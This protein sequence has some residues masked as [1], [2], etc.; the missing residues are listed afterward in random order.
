MKKIVSFNVAG[1]ASFYTTRLCQLYD[2]VKR[3]QGNDLASLTP[4]KIEFR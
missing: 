1:N 4:W 2:C 3:M